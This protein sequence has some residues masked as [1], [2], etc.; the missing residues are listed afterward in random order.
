M[1]TSVPLPVGNARL[2]P[3]TVFTKCANGFRAGADKKI[4]TGGQIFSPKTSVAAARIRLLH[5]K[6]LYASGND[7]QID[8]D[9]GSPVI[10]ITN[11]AK[12]AS[13][14]NVRPTDVINRD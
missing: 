9:S 5:V 13:G 14:W 8:N 4:D 1:S 10:D 3:G 2:G 7:L 11:S 6:H 12:V